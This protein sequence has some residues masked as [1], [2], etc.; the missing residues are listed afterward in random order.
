MRNNTAS[1]RRQPRRAPV[2]ARFIAEAAA[3][4]KSGKRIRRGDLRANPVTGYV[5]TVGVD[6]LRRQVVDAAAALQA[7][8]RFGYSII[9]GQTD[10]SD[11]FDEDGEEFP[12]LETAL[13][14]HA[15]E[16]MKVTEMPGRWRDRPAR[17]DT[18][19]GTVATAFEERRESQ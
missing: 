7:R 13:R 17:Y 1:S 6:P 8:H 10:R 11:V 12:D 19:Q 16:L 2:D 5:F 4:L 18:F 14:T 3:L 15:A 9:T